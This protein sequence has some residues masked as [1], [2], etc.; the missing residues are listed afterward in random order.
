MGRPFTPRGCRTTGR[1]RHPNHRVSGRWS[2]N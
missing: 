2:H 1:Y